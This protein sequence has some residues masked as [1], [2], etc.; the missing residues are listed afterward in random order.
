MRHKRSITCLAIALLLFAACGG[1]AATATPSPTPS[2]RATEPPRATAPAT[3]APTATP[4]PGA[5]AAPTPKPTAAPTAAPAGAK[6]GGTVR[7]PQREDPPSWDPSKT[8]VDPMITV[9]YLTFTKLFTNWSDNPQTCQSEVYPWAVQS[10]RWVDDTTAEFTLKP[11]IKY[12]NKPPVNG[13]EAVAQDM[14]PAFERYKKNLSFMAGKSATVE[15]V[16]VTDKYTFRMKLKSPW[17]G[18]VSE[19]L[20]HFYGPWLEPAE[21]GGADGSLWEQPAKSWIGSGAFLFDSWRPGVKWRLVR[22]PDY[23]V[24][25]RPYLDAVEMLVIPEA[26]TQLAALRSGQLNM[27]R[28]FNEEMLDVAVRDL[29]GLQVARCAGTTISGSGMLWLNNSGP[30]FDDVR[31]RRAV[32]MAVDNESLVKTLYK[33]RA[34]VGPV[35]PPTVQYAMKA[36]DFPSDLQ[37][38]LKYD[39]ARAKQLLAEA[40]YPTG[41]D[42]AINFTLRY[43]AP[44][45]QVAEALAG[46]LGEIGIRAKLNIQEYGRYTQTVLRAA[47]P[48]GELAITPRTTVTP[49]DAHALTTYWSQAGAVNRSVVKD[50]EYDALFDQFRATTDENKRQNLA[51]QLQIMAANKAYAVTLPMNDSTMVALRGVHFTWIGSTRD[52]SML[53]ETAWMD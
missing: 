50:P 33:G 13:R 9:K 12:H 44:A 48:V 36:E 26:S 52:Y 21:A 39:P 23:W 28:E 8:H 43:A 41:F 46:M 40:G 49:E 20:A 1:P 2:A 4:L 14:V 25:G 11:G 6:L 18:L 35:L 42:S 27:I 53:L 38:F 32:R 3:A 7:H 19:L 22:N 47:Y 51:R 29:P 10:W 24:K 5:T 31:V 37:P 16:T 15:S 17:G 45:N 34:A 30:P